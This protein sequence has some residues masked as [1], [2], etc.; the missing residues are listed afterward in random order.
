MFDS[1]TEA[2]K[3]TFIGKVKEIIENLKKWIDEFLSS[4][5]TQSEETRLL[6][7]Y[8]DKLE[9]MSEI[10]DQ[11]LVR[12]IEVNQALERTENKKSTDTEGG[13]MQY[14]PK[15]VGYDDKLFDFGVTQSEIN[16]YVEKAYQ[17]ENNKSYIKYLAAS[18]HLIEDVSSDVDISGYSHALRDNDIR[19]I[20]NSHGE[21]TNEKYPV[22]Q[23]DI[24]MIPFVVENY[25]KVFY[26]TNASGAPGLVFV[27]VMPE[28]VIYYVEA[29]TK[30]YGKEKLLVNKQMIK[31]GIHEIPNL[32]GLNDAI[33]KKESS[34]QYLAD[35]EK[36]RKAYVQD[37][38]ENY[39]IKSI[40]NSPEKSNDEIVNNDDVQFSEKI[41]AN[42]S[43]DE[44]YKILKDKKIQPQVIEIDESV[45]IDF[46]YLKENSKKIVEEP[47]VRKLNELN[48]FKKYKTIVVSNVE[49]EFTKSGFRK[50][51]N[52]QEYE[53]GGKKADFAKVMLNLQ[54]LL[55]SSVLIE[56]HTDKARGTPKENTELKQVYVLMS[57]FQENGVITPVQFEIKQYINENNRLYLAV[58]LTK[59]ETSVMGSA[60][61]ENQVSTPL[62]PVSGISIAELF[63]NVNALDKN[64]LKY[65]PSQFLNEEQITA[66]NKAIDIEK[67]KYSMPEN[68]SD[69]QNSDKSTTSVYDLMGESENIVKEYS[70]EALISK[71]DMNV[72]LF[73]AVVPGN[74]ADIVYQA[75]RNAE[76]IGK[77]SSKDKSVSVYVEDI[78]KEIVLSTKG[79][80]HG[81]RRLRNL[82][83]DANSFAAVKAGEILKN[84]IR[85]NK[86]TPK[87]QNVDSSYVLIGVA[88]SITDD[89]FI[90]RSVINHYNNEL[91]SM[92]VLYSVNAKKE[93]AVH[94]APPITKDSLRITDST[95][96]ISDLLEYVN[97]YFPDILP[98]SV[99]RHFG[100]DARPEGEMGEDALF[101]DKSTT[102]GYDLMGESESIVKENK[103][104]AEDVSRLKEIIG[105]EDIAN[106]KYLSLA[107][108]LKKLSGS[109]I[110]SA[111]LGK[112]LKDA[113]TSMK[114]SDDLT[115]EDVLMNTEQIAA[116]LMNGK[117][118]K[119]SLYKTMIF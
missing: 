94:N 6:R 118:T 105:A 1:M 50:S 111:K 47:L 4:Y 48:V 41:T 117:T 60:V 86:L 23:S 56:T 19:H 65:I 63:R 46:E 112:M 24:Q 3:K 84:S 88:K 31:T 98:E 99:L 9:E 36:I 110:D 79:L 100:Y 61:L 91:M 75:K 83:T 80:E 17:K 89:L 103:M 108:Y 29:I 21:N 68:D 95:I 115:W 55:D 67:R 66:K 38:K 39:S 58:A 87:K 72:I 33:N 25:D 44:R 71:P 76:K 82:Q 104:L 42:M 101:S 102:S 7:E 62:L 116:S 81:L 52:S 92:D 107:K 106:S 96:S 78:G 54:K 20:R 18:S 97:M 8:K 28:N 30:E 70:Y 74:R 10:W 113:Y 59:I 51:I 40:S 64:L 53:Y 27:K 11:M 45:D 93:S 69:F 34:S 5:G 43:E 57:A 12:S 37:V 85:I 32:V 114:K 22:T 90:I 35:L 119:Q 15:D 14:S 2:E 77:L 73:D 109:N 26:K 13:V 16:S 49:F